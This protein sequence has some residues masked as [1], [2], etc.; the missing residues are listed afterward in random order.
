MVLVILILVFVFLWTV[1]D[2]LLAL[3]AC[4]HF[5]HH[6]NHPHDYNTQYQEHQDRP[7]ILVVSPSRVVVDRLNVTKEL[8]ITPF[9]VVLLISFF[10]LDNVDTQKTSLHSI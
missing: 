6:S 2:V 5:Y 4:H 1:F 7:R 8:R 3:M 9:F 10:E